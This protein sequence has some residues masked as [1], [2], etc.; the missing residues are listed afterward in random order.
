MI[1]FDDSI[2]DLNWDLYREIFSNRVNPNGCPALGTFYV[3]H[4]WTD[5]SQVQTLYSEGH[6]MASHSITY[7][8][9]ESLLFHHFNWYLSNCRHSFGE[10]FSKEKWLKEISGQ[11]EILHLYGGVKYND[12]RGMRAPFLQ[13]GGNAQF[14]MLYEA[15]FTYDS[16]LP[17]GENNPPYWP[18]TF[19]YAIGHNCAIPP[20]PTRSFPGTAFD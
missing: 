12:V 9:T 20:C 17:V 13:P 8:F 15:N 18:Y 4:E 6:E 5:Y 7:V 11:R 10:K 2:N 3:S 16:S 1:T 19:D 14:E